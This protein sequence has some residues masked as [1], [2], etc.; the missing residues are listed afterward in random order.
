MSSVGSLKIGSG[1]PVS[2]DL[3]KH[4]KHGYKLIVRLMFNGRHC[5]HYSIRYNPA[6]TYFTVSTNNIPDIPSFGSED[7]LIILLEVS[8]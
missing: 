4:I 7:Y 5:H 8:R 2:F 1:K 6:S 3:I